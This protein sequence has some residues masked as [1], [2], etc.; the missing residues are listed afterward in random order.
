[1]GIELMVNTK[2]FCLSFLDHSAPMLTLPPTSMN[3][4]Y[5]FMLPPS[6]VNSL[7]REH[8][9]CSFLEKE[10]TKLHQQLS[11]TLGFENSSDFITVSPGYSVY[12][13]TTMI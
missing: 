12:G 3:N 13:K 10:D 2:I 9:L 6:M 8:M 11:S 7:I 5:S 1:M 4:Y